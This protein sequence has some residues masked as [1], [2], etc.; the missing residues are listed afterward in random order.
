MT[1]IFDETECGEASP[2]H[3]RITKAQWK[4]SIAHGYASV[5]NGQRYI[6]TLDHATQATTLVP[7]EVVG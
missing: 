1:T 3:R 6:L 7:V 4:A 2:T 5:T